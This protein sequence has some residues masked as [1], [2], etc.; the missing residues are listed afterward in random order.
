MLEK[1]RIIRRINW[2]QHIKGNTKMHGTFGYQNKFKMKTSV[3]RG[4]KELRKYYKE[5]NH[6]FSTAMLFNLQDW[7]SARPWIPHSTTRWRLTK[8]M[9]DS[10]AWL[11]PRKK[12]TETWCE[13]IMDVAP[14]LQT[15]RHEHRNWNRQDGCTN[16]VKPTKSGKVWGSSH[17]DWTMTAVAPEYISIF[18]PTCWSGLFWKWWDTKSAGVREKCWNGIE[19]KMPEI[20]KEVNGLR[21]G[22]VS[23]LSRKKFLK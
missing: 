12:P 6:C 7:Y 13:L 21:I 1:R 3:S 17:D 14:R 23:I 10:V 20:S 18:Q 5:A 9:M 22:H 19:E 11:Q 4:R 2:K 15:R 16:W 8:S